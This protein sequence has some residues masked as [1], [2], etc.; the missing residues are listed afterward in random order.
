MGE[1][2]PEQIESLAASGSLPSYLA[3]VYVFGPPELYLHRMWRYMA[4]GCDQRIASL[5]AWGWLSFTREYNALAVEAAQAWGEVGIAIE[6]ALNN[7]DFT[8]AS[9]WRLW[10]ERLQQELKAAA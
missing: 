1:L 10:V 5:A 7:G 6:T 3:R 4:K 2:T 9:G 8:W